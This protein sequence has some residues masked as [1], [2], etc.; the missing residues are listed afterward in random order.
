MH[1]A[2][3]VP[4]FILLECLNC[5]WPSSVSVQ[6]GERGKGNT[7]MAGK[8]VGGRLEPMLEDFQE[9][10]HPSIMAA[11]GCL[12]PTCYPGATV[13][14]GADAPLRSRCPLVEL[15]CRPG[16][17]VCCGV[18]QPPR[19]EQYP[20]L[21]TPGGRPGANLTTSAALELKHWSLPCSCLHL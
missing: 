19:S 4:L 15:M 18:N 2:L 10:R 14:H 21:S 9:Q 13:H 6:S 16:A 3:A 5:H 12:E 7:G 20:G 8:W 11:T 1:G 17:A